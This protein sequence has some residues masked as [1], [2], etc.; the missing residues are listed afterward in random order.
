LLAQDGITLPHATM[1]LEPS[2]APS[3][4]P[5]IVNEKVTQ[6]TRT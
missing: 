2:G 5:P 3:P 6:E 1:S 4:A